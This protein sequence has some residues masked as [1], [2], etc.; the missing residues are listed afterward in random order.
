M[1]PTSP[2]SV[3]ENERIEELQAFVDS[4]RSFG[5][6]SSDEDGYCRHGAYVGGVGPDYMCGMCEQYGLDEEIK[7]VEAYIER[8]R[9]NGLCTC[10]TASRD[11]SLMHRAYCEL[12]SRAL[13][14]ESIR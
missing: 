7:E 2:I 8:I 9:R 13:R 10:V 5:Y 11:P 6:R 1:S 14:G 12:I 3:A 4:V